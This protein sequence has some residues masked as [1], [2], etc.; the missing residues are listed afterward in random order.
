MATLLDVPHGG[1]RVQGAGAHGASF[2]PEL[3]RARGERQ[4]V[5]ISLSG[6]GMNNSDEVL[7]VVNQHKRHPRGRLAAAGWTAA[8]FM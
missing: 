5:L 2:G 7:I 3:Q 8:M 4:R 6:G 1:M